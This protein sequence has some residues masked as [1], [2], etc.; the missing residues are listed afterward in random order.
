VFLDKPSIGDPSG[1]R[2]DGTVGIPIDPLRG[3]LVNGS[4]RTR[5]DTEEGIVPPTLERNS[6]LRKLHS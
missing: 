4:I 5:N 1:V 6:Y 2:S 3:S